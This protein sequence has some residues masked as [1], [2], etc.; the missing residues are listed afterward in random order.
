MHPTY[1]DASVFNKIVIDSFAAQGDL[2]R[3]PTSRQVDIGIAFG[4]PA[5]RRS[6]HAIAT[7]KN[8]WQHDRLTRAR[9]L[10]EVSTAM[11]FEHDQIEVSDRSMALR[12]SRFLNN[13]LP[14]CM[15][16]DS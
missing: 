15:S 12:A 16:L 2:T 3:A 13:R 4:S 14:V 7:A 8:Q 6:F 1:T 9:S 10:T 5:R 11:Q